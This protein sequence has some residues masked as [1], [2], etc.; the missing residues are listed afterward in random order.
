[1]EDSRWMSVMLGFL[2]GTAGLLAVDYFVYASGG[3]LLQ[4]PPETELGVRY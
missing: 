2:V 1:M 3:L 4:P